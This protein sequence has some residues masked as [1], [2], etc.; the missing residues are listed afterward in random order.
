MKKLL[1]ITVLVLFSVPVALSQVTGAETRHDGELPSLTGHARLKQA[2]RLFR[3]KDDL[4]SVIT[5]IPAGTDVEV[6]SSE[7]AFL[8]V[9]CGGNRGFLNAASVDFGKET[10]SADK[11]S[12]TSEKKELRSSGP[13]KSV[14]SNRYENLENKYGR[15]TARRI[16]EGK[17]WKG[18]DAEMVIDS[19]GTPAKIIKLINYNN[20][21][22]EWYYR[23]TRLVF[24]NN[25]LVSWTRAGG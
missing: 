18:M 13:I 24:Q 7:G 12:D 20:V 4:V 5:V 11:V 9:E 2:A 15:E 19:W 14:R 8:E 21:M 16:A 22:E 23:D 17:I 25:K 10:R 6:L 1:F 3:D